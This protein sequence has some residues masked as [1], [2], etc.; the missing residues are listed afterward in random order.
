MRQFI[1]DHFAVIVVLAVFFALYTAYLGIL[2]F[3]VQGT[4]I[5]DWLEGEMKEVIGAVLMGLTGR[6]AVTVLNGN[7][8]TDPPLEPPKGA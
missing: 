3:H 2:F 4:S 8:K 1:D 5:V 6:G 7:R